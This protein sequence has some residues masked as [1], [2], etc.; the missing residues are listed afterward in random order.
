METIHLNHK[1]AGGVTDGSWSLNVYSRVS[2]STNEIEGPF[3]HRDLSSILDSKIG[4][5]PC[6]SPPSLSDHRT[7]QV[8]QLRPNTFH[9]GG[10]L[11]W[12]ARNPFV[13]AP[14]VYSPT[15]WVRRR[16]CHSEFG[17]ILDVPE[18]LR[19]S[20][21]P[22]LMSR[23]IEDT[24]FVPEHVLVLVLDWLKLD[25]SPEISNDTQVSRE[26]SHRIAKN[27]TESSKLPSAGAPDS[28]NKIADA[29]TRN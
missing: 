18:Q 22:T 16:L 23:L 14:C 28:L 26:F 15:G 21:A 17:N 7:P 10:L 19:R 12:N 13:I 24:S 2:Q 4:G 27:I 9:G 29:E 3:S 1:N 6:P 11:P 8:W 20:L 5:I 25:A